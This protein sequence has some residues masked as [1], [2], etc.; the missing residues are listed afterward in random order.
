LKITRSNE[1]KKND[2]HGQILY[3]KYCKKKNS[4]M[5]NKIV[6]FDFMETFTNGYL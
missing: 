6:N 2:V 4:T 3:Y 1:F 5:K